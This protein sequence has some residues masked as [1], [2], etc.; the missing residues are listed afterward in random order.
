MLKNI[1]ELNGVKTLEKKSQKVIT[2]GHTGIN[3][4]ECPEA[5]C[6]MWDQLTFKPFCSC[7]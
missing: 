6:Q 4:S 2:G 3:L 1:L 7:N 5:V